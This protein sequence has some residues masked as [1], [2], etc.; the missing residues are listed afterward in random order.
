MG[1]FSTSAHMTKQTAGSLSNISTSL[2][3]S[4][5]IM[6]IYALVALNRER[7]SGMRRWYIPLAIACSTVFIEILALLVQAH[8]RV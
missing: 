6:L 5:V 4:A 2:H 8:A 7:V 3:M 1:G